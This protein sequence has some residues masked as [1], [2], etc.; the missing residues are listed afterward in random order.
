MKTGVS[1]NYKSEVLGVETGPG[2]KNYLQGKIRG[3]FLHVC[4]VQLLQ[5]N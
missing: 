3:V 5:N 2:T 4:L 1:V